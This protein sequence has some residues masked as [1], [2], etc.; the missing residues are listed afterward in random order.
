MKSDLS[1]FHEW[2]APTHGPHAHAPE[3]I[4]LTDV[5]RLT[6]HAVKVNHAGLA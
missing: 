1:I 2:E 3:Y 6:T 5:E 4:L